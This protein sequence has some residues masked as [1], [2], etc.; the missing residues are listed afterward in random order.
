MLILNRRV[1]E[2]IKV[3]DSVEITVTFIG[4]DTVAIGIDAPRSVRILRKELIPSDKA[5]PVPVG[6]TNPF[7]S[8]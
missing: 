1:G 3:G 4:K 6:S 2:V 5:M 7:F 8:T